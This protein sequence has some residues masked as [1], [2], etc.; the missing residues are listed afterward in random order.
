[1][2]KYGLQYVVAG[3][4]ILKS[5]LNLVGQKANDKS[6]NAPVENDKATTAFFKSAFEVI[7]GIDPTGIAG[8][9]SAFISD[10]CISLEDVYNP[11]DL[12]TNGWEITS[13]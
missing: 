11:E 2:S 13:L 5:S 12:L 10:R 6:G 9:I 8:V 4:N 3:A 7:N 1:M